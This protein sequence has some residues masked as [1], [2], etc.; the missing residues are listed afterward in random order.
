M[1]TPD[2]YE[3]DLLQFFAGR[4]EALPLYH[5]L[6]AAMEQAFPDASLKV[7]KTQISFYGRHLFAAVSLPRRKG[8]P[9]LVLTIGLCCRLESP[10][11]SVAVEPYPNRWTH[12]IPLTGTK[13]IDE[14]LL[15]W[16]QAAYDWAERK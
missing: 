6:Y 3:P 9:G 7:Q 4:P 11:V 5:S 14:E 8:E 12:H 1:H 13:Q 2:Y 10:R 15:S 16:L